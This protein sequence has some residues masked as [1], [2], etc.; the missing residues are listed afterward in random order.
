[1]F[2]K[3]GAITEKIIIPLLAAAITGLFVGL[4]AL[5]LCL[6]L[7]KPLAWALLAAALAM[8]G[9][10][11]FRPLDGLKIPESPAAY[12]QTTKIH[13]LTESGDAGDYLQFSIDRAR[14][15][16]FARELAAGKSFTSRE[17]TGRGALLSGSEF[18][19]LR[20]ELINR[21]YARWNS[22]RDARSGCALTAKGKAMVNGLAALPS[23]EALTKK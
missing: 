23:P 21:G 22:D 4:A 19:R 1:M 20:G 8:L 7:E 3:P 10:W 18:V 16:Q 17:W 2:R 13:V 15:L 9:A 6:T 11:I 14:L 12:Q 5:A